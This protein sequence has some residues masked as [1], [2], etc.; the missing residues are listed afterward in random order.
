[1]SKNT[2]LGRD[3]VTEVL[4]WGDQNLFTEG[5]PLGTR[6]EGG[7]K[8]GKQD[9]GKIKRKTKNEQCEGGFDQGGRGVRAVFSR[10]GG[11]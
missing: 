2:V 3:F 7:H 8:V 11:S 4:R 1:M 9:K 5:E 6:L 10:L